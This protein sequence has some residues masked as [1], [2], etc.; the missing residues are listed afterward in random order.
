MKLD[1]THPR[2]H[3]QTVRFQHALNTLGD[4]K[5]PE[6]VSQAIAAEFTAVD[7]STDLGAHNAA[8]RDQHPNSTRH[9]LAALSAERAIRA[10]SDRAGLENE[11]VAL[12]GNADKFEDALAV[13]DTVKAWGCK[14]TVLEVAKRAGKEKWPAVTRF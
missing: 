14:E 2:V 6:Q 9:Q 12:V 10:D 4:N 5:L 7:G 1:A 11:L 13:I 8:F 3:E